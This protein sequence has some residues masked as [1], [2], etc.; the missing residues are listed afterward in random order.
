M[1]FLNKRGVM[2]DWPI[3]LTILFIAAIMIFFSCWAF[4]ALKTEIISGGLLTG[5]A[6]ANDILN[7]G[8]NVANGFDLLLVFVFNAAG[9]GLLITAWF[10]D[11]RP[12]FAIIGLVL[13][14]FMIIVGAI[15]SNVFDEVTDGDQFADMKAEFDLT[16]FVLNQ[17]PL[18]ILTYLIL[19]AIVFFGKNTLA[20]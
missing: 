20:R 10:I 18:F 13:L 1:T 11:T 16:T 2:Q 3:I 14:G 7:A 4:T 8:Q 9:L 15:F 19:S 6:E 5:N 17:Y 12:I